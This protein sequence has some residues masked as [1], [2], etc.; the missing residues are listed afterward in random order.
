MTLKTSEPS[1]P[2]W[3]TIGLIGRGSYGAVYEIQRDVLGELEKAALKVVSIPQHEND[4]A[5]LFSEGYSEESITN[6]FREH[7]KSIVGEYS[8]MRKM[9]GSA[10]VV[11]CDDVRYIQHDD[12]IGWDVY[13]KMELL[14]PLTK[15][16]P[17]PIPEDMVI[18]TAKDLCAALILCKKHGILHRDIKP[19]NIFVSPNGDYKLGDFGIA[20][21]VEHTSNGTK[22]G[23]YKYMAPEI[24]NNRPYGITSDIY[25][26]G[27]V[28]YWLLNERRLPFLPLPPHPLKAG[29]DEDARI[30]RLSGEPLPPPAHGS[31]RL[32]A[33]VLKACAYQAKYRYQTP[34]EMLDA[35]EALKYFHS[36]AAVPTI[37]E[38]P[39][40]SAP[41]DTSS[42]PDTKSGTA[43]TASTEEKQ[44]VSAAQPQ[45][46]PLHQALPAVIPEKMVIALARDLCAALTKKREPGI[47]RQDIEPK[48]IFLTPEGTY[49]LEAA[50]ATAKA[51]SGTI[52]PGSKHYMAPEVC[53]QKPY[54]VTAEIYSLGM[55]L[56]WLLNQRRMPF[57]PLPPRTTTPQI[58]EASLQQRLSGKP[59]PP[60]VCGSSALKGIVLKACVFKPQYRYRS[61]EE[62]LE[63]LNH[64]DDPV[65]AQ[66]KKTQL[67]PLVNVLP[68]TIPEQAVITLAKDLCTALAKSVNPDM[69]RQD[70]EPK[71]IFLTSEG[72]YQLKSSGR[73][74]RKSSGS[75]R[76]GSIHFMAPEV[77]LNRPFGVTAEIYSLG[78]VLYWLLNQRRMPF[79]AQ[80]AP[81]DLDDASLRY[82]LS[83]KPLPPPVGGSSALK[84]IVLKACVSMP[85]YRYQSYREMLEAL[86]ALSAAVPV[87]QPPQNTDTQEDRTVG[88]WTSRQVSP[89]Q[90]AAA[91]EAGTDPKVSAFGKDYDS[92]Q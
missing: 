76:M 81:S 51:G 7:L 28:L 17:T 86:N 65:A 18:A 64:L 39:D 22:I 52:R 75:I 50:A 41:Q 60:P 42:A 49:H 82:R 14:T 72:K 78:M 66:P 77:Y 20:K 29:V 37:T 79:Q 62:L 80:T 43:D 57:E 15:F 73:T 55:V 61:H 12:G 68:A 89:V 33:I 9:N 6:T 85:Q 67:T 27:M 36:A 56:Y 59:L 25:S 47:I 3:E 38:T 34:E 92:L 91:P 16:L 8:M 11:N 4:I 13:I 1:W 45:L 24:Y 23:T 48:N 46:K 83:G 32:K 5:E 44:Q 71:N 90:T 69:I 21:V 54:D 70:I 40:V 35:L 84:A 74:L 26:L 53:Q 10:N 2:G 87:P 58:K 31:D 88:M 19:Q 63:A 30:R